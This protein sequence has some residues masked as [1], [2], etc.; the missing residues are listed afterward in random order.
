M[1]IRNLMSSTA[2]FS[3][4]RAAA[5]ES[6]A[7]DPPATP[8]AEDD[9][10]ATGDPPSGDD[11][12]PPATDPPAA[13]PPAAPVKD[14]RDREIA[15]KH[16]QNLELKRR[17]DERAA[18][19]AELERENDSLRAIA[20][21]RAATA[22]GDDN[23][24]PPPAPVRRPA[25][26]APD[27]DAVKQEAQRLVAKETYDRDCNAAFKKGKSDYGEKWDAAVERLATLGGPEGSID[28]D[29]MVGILAT[30]DPARVLFE[31]GNNPDEYHRVMG[32]PPAKRLNE[33]AKIASAPATKKQV[34][35]APA[36][37]EPVGGRGAKVNDELDDKL[38]DDEWYARRE[39]QKRKKWEAS[40]GIRRSA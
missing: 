18:R 1:L 22:Q 37:V 39:A 6:G 36:P 29:T 25:S 38:S 19:L 10:D 11:V 21:R 27:Q 26:N 7:G 5:S 32:L 24:T 20:E 35:N 14:W 13:S 15:A 8:A 12:T 4:P 33:M 2:L 3:F 17:D 30:D 28:I 34:S 16:R 9:G 31:L 40:Q 23:E